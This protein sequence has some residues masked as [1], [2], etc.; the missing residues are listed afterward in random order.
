LAQ[1]DLGLRFRILQS[2]FMFGGEIVSHDGIQLEIESAAAIAAVL[3]AAKS[4]QAQTGGVTPVASTADESAHSHTPELTWSESSLQGDPSYVH[5]A[6]G[7]AALAAEKEE[8]TGGD[9]SFAHVSAEDGV[10][11][12][13]KEQAAGGPGSARA[14]SIE[15]PLP[16]G[17]GSYFRSN[18]IAM[19]KL[20]SSAMQTSRSK[21]QILQV[22][23][24]V[25]ALSLPLVLLMTVI[26]LVFCFYPFLKHGES[27]IRICDARRAFY[28]QEKEGLPSSEAMELAQTGRWNLAS[29]AVTLLLLC[30]LQAMAAL[31]SPK[32]RLT[33]FAASVCLLLLFMWFGAGFCYMY[34]ECVWCGQDCEEAQKC[35]VVGLIRSLFHAAA[36]TWLVWLLRA[37]VAGLEDVRYTRHVTWLAALASVSL[38][39][40]SVLVGIT[41]PFLDNMEAN[42][43]DKLYYVAF[44][45][46]SCWGAALTIAVFVVVAAFAEPLKEAVRLAAEADSHDAEQLQLFVRTGYRN[47]ASTVVCAFATFISLLMVTSEA[48]LAMFVDDGMTRALS[49]A[50][51]ACR[52]IDAGLKG[53]SILMLGGL[54]PGLRVAGAV[55]RDAILSSPRRVQKLSPWQGQGMT[56]SCTQSCMSPSCTAPT[57]AWSDTV[58]DLSLR[59][60]T[61]EALLDFYVEL[62]QDLMPNFNPMVHTTHD[63]V[64]QAIIPRSRRGMPDGDGTPCALASILMHG[65]PT[66]PEYMVTHHWGNKFADL[67]AAIVGKALGLRSFKGLR[68]EL[69]Q[70]LDGLRDRLRLSG[71][72]HSTWWICAISVNQHAS[73]CDTAL[74][75]VDPITGQDICRCTCNHPK[76]L[77]CEYSEVNKFD[78]MM[79]RCAQRNPNFGHVIAV[80]RDFTLFSRC[81]CVAEV[82]AGRQ[83]QL[84]QSLMLHSRDTIASHQDQLQNLRIEEMQASVASDKERILAQ[85]H[86]KE[87][88]NRELREMVLNTHTGLLACWE[89]AG[90]Y[91]EALG[92]LISTRGSHAPRSSQS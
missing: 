82:H 84:H 52:P 24:G 17:E 59:A 80:D 1:A 75:V 76:Y 85:I 72:L 45:L 47:V 48:F 54:W 53:V 14:G 8:V 68:G 9:A 3:N 30:F 61:L 58:E 2:S 37:L 46:M 34:S 16:A 32:T 40:V 44:A 88:F 70:N 78:D 29:D 11:A 69:T 64:R 55:A 18:S 56:I 21:L 43:L 19:S 39:V 26:T 12:A 66:A 73:I 65:Q 74:G 79:I 60:V 15:N 23:L 57:Q 63:V 86:D 91:T 67:I 42:L 83:L 5:F 71:T 62:K 31:G 51:A 92:R 38:L 22:F 50:F 6:A 33:P 13:E 7:D 10:V 4:A 36:G 90:Q 25:R 87:R 20:D 49:L 81:W 27:L 89:D 41:T 28:L 77:D 35:R